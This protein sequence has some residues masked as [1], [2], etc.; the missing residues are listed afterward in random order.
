MASI[1]AKKRSSLAVKFAAT[2]HSTGV[3][4]RPLAYRNPPNNCRRSI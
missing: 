2:A 1:A 4:Q 3:A